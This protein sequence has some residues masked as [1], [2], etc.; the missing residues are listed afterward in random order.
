MPTVSNIF[1]NG[2]KAIVSRSLANNKVETMRMRHTNIV[3][4]MLSLAVK[5]SVYVD[6]KTTALPKS[7]E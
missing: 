7:V 1:S 3:L 6:S 5:D 4:P 2:S